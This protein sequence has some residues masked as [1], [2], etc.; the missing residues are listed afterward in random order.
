[1][2]L[3][4]LV[5]KREQVKQ[6]IEGVMELLNK[7][8]ESLDIIETEISNQMGK[9]GV[10]KIAVNGVTCWIKQEIAPKVTD[11]DKVYNYINETGRYDIL[12]KTIKKSSFKELI[13][14]GQIIPGV[15]I[16]SFEKISFRKG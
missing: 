4:Q 15:E 6:K 1:M 9:E 12:T 16:S 13:D 7:H 11:W 8:K 14:N 5:D 3:K 2:N 10:E